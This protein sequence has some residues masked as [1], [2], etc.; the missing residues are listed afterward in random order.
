MLSGQFKPKPQL[1]VA[2]VADLHPAI[3]C[4]STMAQPISQ[5][6]KRDPMINILIP[7]SSIIVSYRKLPNLKDLLCLPDQN[8]FAAGQLPQS[9][10][11]Y[12]DTGC[13]CDVCKISTFG[14]FVSP[15][16][17]PGY[18]IPIQGPTTCMSGPA[19]IYHLIC[20][21]GRPECSRA[22]YVGLAST[23]KDGVKPMSARWSNHK[24]HHKKSKNNCQMTEHLMTCHK[25]EDAQNF[26]SITILEACSTVEVA[27]ERE[28]VWTFD[29]FAFQPS[30]LN[31][32]EE[33]KED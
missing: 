11:G 15:P 25:N 6:S 27:R 24:S 5:I 3:T 1:K 13:R 21:S 31:K 30:G 2:L 29:L 18:K 23:T 8:K 17:M 16:S 22:H 14:K 20:N 19:V 12:V 7:P 9:R 32:R 28:I 4:L 10:F 26:V 33:S